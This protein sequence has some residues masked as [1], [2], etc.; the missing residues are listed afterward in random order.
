MWKKENVADDL[1]IGDIAI[2]VRG[3]HYIIHRVQDIKVNV[4]GIKEFIFKGDVN[5]VS[6]PDPVY[7]EQIQGRYLSIAGDE[8][9]LVEFVKSIYGK[10]ITALILI[11]LITIEIVFCGRSKNN[12]VQKSV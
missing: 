3:D 5:E 2:Y 12:G 11:L 8:Y 9:Y 7:P 4:D 10:V 1:Q 6:D